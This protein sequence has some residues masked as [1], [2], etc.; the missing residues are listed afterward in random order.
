[1]NLE[2]IVILMADKIAEAVSPLFPNIG[3]SELRL[4]TG[5]A[6][7]IWFT[8]AV[9]SSPTMNFVDPDLREGLA[10]LGIRASIHNVADLTSEA[11]QKIIAGY[12]RRWMAVIYVSEEGATIL[13]P[14]D[15]AGD[16]LALSYP[17]Q[18]GN[19]RLQFPHQNET[20]GIYLVLR[21]GGKRMRPSLR[22]A[23]TLLTWISHLYL[24]SRYALIRGA[25]IY[26]AHRGFGAIAGWR[27]SLL[28]NG[29]G[30]SARERADCWIDSFSTMAEFLEMLA[31]R[32]SRPHQRRYCAADQVLREQLLPQLLKLKLIV[33]KDPSRRPRAA[34]R[35]KLIGILDAAERILGEAVQYAMDGLSRQMRLP[36][37]IDG[38]LFDGIPISSSREAIQAAIYMARAGKPHRRMLAARRLSAVSWD[39]AESTLRQLLYDRDPDLVLTAAR[40]LILMGLDPNRELQTALQSAIESGAPKDT[41]VT[42]NLCLLSANQY[43]NNIPWPEF[44]EILSRFGASLE[45]LV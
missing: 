14:A 39:A 10:L 11:Y 20:S 8:D 25:G 2:E 19:D 44:E 13:N 23:E 26:R 41:I 16:G 5:I 37:D 45:T 6:G 17:D 34:D 35:R 24:P 28:K 18:R 21:R 15:A 42:R 29:L 12:K 7:M 3:Y 32:G 22:R 30:A 40:S 38:A 27:E 31:G 9:G 43:E 36:P 4:L 33:A 1:M